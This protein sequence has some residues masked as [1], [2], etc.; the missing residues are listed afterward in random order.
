MPCGC[1]RLPV[2][3]GDKRVPEGPMVIPYDDILFCF[4]KALHLQHNRNKIRK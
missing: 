1:N 4:P 2:P 3:A